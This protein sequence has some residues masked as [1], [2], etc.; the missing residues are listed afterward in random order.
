MIDLALF[1]GQRIAVL[2]LGKSGRATA[3]ALASAGVEVLAWDD[4]EGARET[5]ASAGI[6]VADLYAA[7][8]SGL[9]LLV[10]SPG[11]PH[12]HPQPHALAERAR[13]AGCSIVC[14]VELLVRARRAGPAPGR[15]VGIT[16][17][18]GKSTTTALIGHILGHAGRECAVG[19]NIGI[20]ALSLPG[21]SGE[22]I[23]VLEL[24]SYQLE[25]TPGLHCD[26]AVL[27]NLSE[28][29]LERHGGFEGYLAAKEHV[30]DG[31]IGGDTAVLGTDDAAARALRDRL[32][33]RAGG[34]VVLSI[35]AGHA[36][37]GGVYAEGRRLI[38]DLGGDSAPVMDLDEASALPGGHN[39]QNAAAAYTV[40]RRL[41]I[42]RATIA[43]A[44]R[45]FPGLPHRQ[46]LVGTLDGI[47]YVNDSKATN[48]D[49]AARAVS[50]YDAIYWIAGGQA[51][52]GGIEAVAPYFARIVHAF[53]IGDA[54]D[55]FARRLDGQVAWTI[56]GDL[57]SAVR[58]AHA[59]AAREGPDR[60]VVLLSPAC[61][62]F[63]Q[64]ANF[65]A[66]GEA[67]RAAIAAL[68][69]ARSEASA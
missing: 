34:P 31:Q 16:G 11:I 54:A 1:S 46:E 4:S 6:P 63:D 56:C 39:A 14:D 45:V 43:D 44:I 41:G 60:A 52:A 55:A 27:L 61:A 19:G 47:R 21:L 35:S 62:S 64:F 69:R 5:A 37:P 15:F 42:P 50:S 57:D 65:E 24:S 8:W 10:L 23:Y 30:F 25:L 66:R 32:C 12:R 20:P 18:N 29:H 33:G 36:E 38:D 53:L 9:D 58:A 40:A 48:G 51:K 49:S 17:T 3:L 7:D 67:F 13:R 59:M 2:G 26:I 68:P 22:G 28:D